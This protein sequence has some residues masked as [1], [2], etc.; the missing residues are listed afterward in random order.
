MAADIDAH[1]TGIAYVIRAEAC[2]RLNRPRDTLVHGQ[3]TDLIHRCDDF[4]VYEIERVL[5][6]ENPKDGKQSKPDSGSGSDRPT[7]KSE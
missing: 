4:I 7:A 5:A 2:R 3:F 1:A 6:M